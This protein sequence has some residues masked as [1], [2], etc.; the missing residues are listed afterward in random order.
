MQ[1]RHYIVFFL[2][3]C[4][5]CRSTST[6]W[7]ATHTNMTLHCFLTLQV[8]G[9]D[10]RELAREGGG[11]V[12]HG[13]GGAP[14]QRRHYIVFLLITRLWRRSTRT[15]WRRW[16]RRTGWWSTHTKTALQSHLTNYMSMAQI[17]EDSLEKVG[18]ENGMVV[19]PY[20]DDLTKS[21]Y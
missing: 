4:P 2:I 3:T 11:G 5:W 15:H 21:S 1:R 17:Y 6:A 8:Y 10:L 19:H 20:K 7:W 16:G 13:G 12:Q 14:I 18:E 9:A